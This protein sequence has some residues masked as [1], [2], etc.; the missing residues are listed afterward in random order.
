VVGVGVGSFEEEV[1]I[2]SLRPRRV[3]EEEEEEEGRI[4]GEEGRIGVGIGI[5]E[6]RMGWEERWW[7]RRPSFAVEEEGGREEKEGQRIEFRASRREKGRWE[8]S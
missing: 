6:L 2:G 1:G 3:L 8:A 7:W 4:E 5:E